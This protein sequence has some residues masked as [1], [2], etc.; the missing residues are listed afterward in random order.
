MAALGL[1]YWI[2][3]LTKR[4]QNRSFLFRMLS[5]S[6]GVSLINFIVLTVTM[7]TEYNKS[8]HYI[9]LTFGCILKIST[10][11]SIFIHI[12]LTIDIY[13][14]IKYSL[15]YHQLFSL[16]RVKSI[17]LKVTLLFTFCLILFHF[18]EP[19]IYRIRNVRYLTETFIFMLMLLQCLTVIILGIFTN[20]IQN[21]Q[22]SSLQNLPKFGITAEKIDYLISRKRRVKDIA[23]LNV[24]NVF[25][26]LPLSICMI[27]TLFSSYT[28]LAATVYFALSLLHVLAN[29]F[30]YICFQNDYKKKFLKL[31]KN[32]SRIEVA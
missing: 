17:L 5:I 9:R 27:L 32:T 23:L 1:F 7:D 26:Y 19:R 15:R 22:R 14:A 13:I 20:L 21:R 6:D 24:W 8:I 25:F 18:E 29:P 12:L 10:V 28:Q 2:T 31:L 4:N 30:V 16:A 11:L 3:K